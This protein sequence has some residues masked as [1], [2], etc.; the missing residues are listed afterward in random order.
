VA[1]ILDPV[2]AGGDDRQQLDAPSNQRQALDAAVLGIFQAGGETL[3]DEAI[4]RAA[5]DAAETP[6]SSANLVTVAVPLL[7]AFERHKRLHLYEGGPLSS[8]TCSVAAHSD[9]QHRA[10]LERQL[11]RPG[12]A[13]RLPSLP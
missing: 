9:V 4:D 7:G 8:I 12:T 10:E 2:Q 6:S 5:A 11:A 13:V 3:A 1:A